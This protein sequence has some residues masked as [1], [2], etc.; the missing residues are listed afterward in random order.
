MRQDEL[1]AKVGV[2]ANSIRGYE[3]ARF[4]LTFD[5]LVRIAEALDM[6]PADVVRAYQEVAAGRLTATRR[7]RTVG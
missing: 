6:E 1:A 5:K 7:R 3:H 4:R 2:H